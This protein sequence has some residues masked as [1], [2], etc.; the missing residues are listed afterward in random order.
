MAQTQNS[1]ALGVGHDD[2]VVAGFAVLADG[3]GAEPGKP[4]TSP[5]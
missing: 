4:L 1:L 2:V 5:T 3:L